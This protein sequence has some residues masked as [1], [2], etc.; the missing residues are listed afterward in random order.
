[1]LAAAAA[2]E[3]AGSQGGKRGCGAGAGDKKGKG[4]AALV[5]SICHMDGAALAAFSCAEEGWMEELRRAA[6][7][8]AVLMISTEL[9]FYCLEKGR[10][11]GEVSSLRHT[12]IE[13]IVKMLPVV[14]V[15]TEMASDGM[16]PVAAAIYDKHLSLERS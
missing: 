16:Y 15:Y 13:L 12:T 4:C 14:P 1:M 9:A 8:L 5:Q 10:I 3:L 7:K 2:R 6:G 11:P